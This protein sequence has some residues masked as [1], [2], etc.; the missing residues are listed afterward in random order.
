MLG[1]VAA[2]PAASASTGHQPSPTSTTGHKTSPYATVHDKTITLHDGTR[3]A[4]VTDRYN[5]DEAAPALAPQI[6]SWASCSIDLASLFVPGGGEAKFAVDII[7]QEFT[8]WGTYNDATAKRSLAII[9]W[10]AVPGSSCVDFIV[11]NDHN[12]YFA[13]SGLRK[14]DG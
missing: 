14:T 7:G 10:H 8:T 6:P 11:K 13:D 9:I 5:K 2:A 12:L 4:T 1:V 3:Q